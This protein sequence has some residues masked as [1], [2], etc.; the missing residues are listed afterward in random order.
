[1]CGFALSQ[2]RVNIVSQYGAG[3]VIYNMFQLIKDDI[4]K[5]FDTDIILD[6]APG[7]GGIVAINK[8]NSYAS[9]NNLI[10]GSMN[11]W[12]I[13]PQTNM[14]KLNYSTR[15]YEPIIL[16]GTN[17]FCLVASQKHNISDWQS[18][19]KLASTSAIFYAMD[20]GPNTIEDI[21]FLYINKTLNL[22]MDSVNYKG[23]SQIIPALING[24]V[25][26][27]FFP[28]TVCRNNLD[29]RITLIGYTSSKEMLSIPHDFH[30]TAWIGLFTNQS[31]SKEI[32]KK[33]QTQFEAI[34]NKN[35]DKYSN[36]VLQPE[37]N[38]TGEEFKRF[39]E[40]EHLKWGKILN[41]INR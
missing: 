35:R 8:L 32:N 3:T 25:H 24:D 29:S 37:K 6:P 26:V 41:A 17:Y 27:A 14:S 22:K 40:K 16:T 2:E 11:L 13:L 12:N 4:K 9:G 5:E 33:L 7:A 28:A 18:F 20:N 10:I 34:F 1:M 36:L 21:M 19:V 15:D 39:I 38:L 31:V 23:R 30:F